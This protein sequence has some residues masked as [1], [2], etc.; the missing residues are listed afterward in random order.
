MLGSKVCGLAEEIAAEADARPAIGLEVDA[1]GAPPAPPYLREE[2]LWSFGETGVKGKGSLEI[3]AIH[4][5]LGSYLLK[6]T[7]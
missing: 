5:N 1:S 7:L 2:S 4:T 3:D 6:V